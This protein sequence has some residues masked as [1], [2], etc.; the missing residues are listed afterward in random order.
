LRWSSRPQKQNPT[1]CEEEHKRNW[2]FVIAATQLDL[3]IMRVGAEQLLKTTDARLTCDEVLNESFQK[4][5]ADL[6][7][8]WHIAIE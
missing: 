2:Q 8:K 6:I 4:A 1:P 5:E 3:L 7:K